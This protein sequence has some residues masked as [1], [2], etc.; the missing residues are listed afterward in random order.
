MIDLEKTLNYFLQREVNF[1]IDNKSVKKGRLILCN[2][3]DFYITFYLRHNNEQK[4]YELPYPFNV[5]ITD[6]G[7]IFDYTLN[8]LSCNSDDMLYKL[9]S[10]TKKKNTKIYDNKVLITELI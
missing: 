9:R 2:I 5:S 1:S 4:R 8:T 10:L 6:Q 3:R 7:I